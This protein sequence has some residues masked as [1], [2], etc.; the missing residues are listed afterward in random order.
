MRV[1]ICTYVCICVFM[2]MYVFA[3]VDKYINIKAKLPLSLGF[4]LDSP[5]SKPMI[6]ITETQQY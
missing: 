6:L 4:Y 1:F 3:H 5:M 2:Y